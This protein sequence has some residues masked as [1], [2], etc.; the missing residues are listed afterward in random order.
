[1]KGEV[2]SKGERLNG[3]NQYILHFEKGQMPPV[4]ENGFWSVTAYDSSND[5][6]IDNALNRYCINDRSM[7]RYN[8]DGSL[9]LYIQKERPTEDKAANWLPVCDGDF[10]FILRIYLPKDEAVKSEWPAPEIMKQ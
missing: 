9:D 3:A 10:H 1:M 2:D 4:K 5:L 6:L 8:E 7:V